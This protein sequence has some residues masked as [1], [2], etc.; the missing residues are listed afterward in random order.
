MNADG[1]MQSRD[2]ADASQWA[3]RNPKGGLLV[4]VRCPAA[5]HCRVAEV[6][7]TP[8]GRLLKVYIRGLP[9]IPPDPLL[10][11]GDLANL[12]LGLI[13]GRGKSTRLA[14]STINYNLNDPIPRE[15]RWTMACRCVVGTLSADALATKLREARNATGPVF[16]SFSR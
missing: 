8:H 2:A 12:N 15:A 7:Q 3:I 6:Q 14:D 5:K 16:V 11:R 9:D 1:S 10:P 4:V 13:R